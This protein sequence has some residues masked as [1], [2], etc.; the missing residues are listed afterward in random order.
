M[1]TA[2]NRQVCDTVSKFSRRAVAEHLDTC[3]ERAKVAA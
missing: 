3:A 1:D 2:V